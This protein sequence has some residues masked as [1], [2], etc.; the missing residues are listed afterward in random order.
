MPSPSLPKS[1]AVVL[2]IEISGFLFVK[3]QVTVSPG[4]SSIE[5]I[6]PVM[7][8]AV[9]SVLFY[10][11]ILT[12]VSWFRSTLKRHDRYERLLFR[13]LSDPRVNLRTLPE[14]EFSQ[15]WEALDQQVALL[16]IVGLPVMLSPAVG[17][18]IV[19]VAQAVPLGS[20]LMP[21]WIL[22]IAGG[23]HLW[24]VWLLRRLFHVHLATEQAKLRSAT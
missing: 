6:A 16:L 15:R 22:V 13:W 5:A 21:L 9:A 12:F 8:L 17:G 2:T 11:L 20:T 18:W 24:G 14:R 7:L 10:L 19:L 4:S 3:V 23:Y 1:S